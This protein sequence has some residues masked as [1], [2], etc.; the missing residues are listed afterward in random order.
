VTGSRDKRSPPGGKDAQEREDRRAIF[1][2]GG[3]GQ[4]GRRRSLCHQAGGRH[5]R[6]PVV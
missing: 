2:S 4:E 1:R 3:E 6:R 5:P